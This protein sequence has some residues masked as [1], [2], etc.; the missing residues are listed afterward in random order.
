MSSCDSCDCADK[1]Q[2]PKKGNSYGV[3]IL[4]TEKS[5][6]EVIKTAPAEEAENGGQCK[7]GPS[8]ACTDCTCD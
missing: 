3:V 5:Y 8:C 6:N 4:E 1:T 7:C 2:C